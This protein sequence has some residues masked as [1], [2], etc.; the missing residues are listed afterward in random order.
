MNTRKH[1]IAIRCSCLIL[2]ALDCALL[3]AFPSPFVALVVWL[4]GSL[5]LVVVIAPAESKFKA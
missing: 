1:T 2:L 4:L 3:R 5:A